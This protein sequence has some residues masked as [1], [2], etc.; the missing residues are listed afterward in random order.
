MA[1]YDLLYVKLKKDE[2]KQILDIVN[3]NFEDG[4]DWIK[5]IESEGPIRR[6]YKY[7]KDHGGGVMEEAHPKAYSIVFWRHCRTHYNDRETNDDDR[8]SITIFVILI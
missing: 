4:W 6:A 3:S 8:V 1:V 2:R 7:C 5:N